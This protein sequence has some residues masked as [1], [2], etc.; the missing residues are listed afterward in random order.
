[1]EDKIRLSVVTATGTVFEKTVN[2][3]NIPTDF[4]SVGILK[5]HAPMLC[6]V[7]KGVVRCAFGDGGCAKISVSGGVAN[8][9]DNEV[10]LLASSAELAE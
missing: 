4:G 5:G 7:S 8:I 10:T 6:A 3:V 9:A 1:M 2:Y